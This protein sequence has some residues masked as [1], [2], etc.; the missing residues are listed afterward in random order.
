M[1]CP[2]RLF[3]VGFSQEQRQ[4]SWNSIASIARNIWNHIVDFVTHPI[5]INIDWPS[6]PSWL[7]SVLGGGG[8]SIPSRGGSGGTS[9]PTGSSNPTYARARARPAFAGPVP[10]I[11]I[12]VHTGPLDSYAARRK[13]ASQL[14][15]IITNTWVREAGGQ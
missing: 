12:H 15:K 2:D 9:N 14:S 4:R 8:P 11:E 13:V 5:S 10:K 7:T 6:P 1:A 3:D